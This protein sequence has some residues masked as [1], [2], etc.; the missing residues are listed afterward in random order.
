MESKNRFAAYV[1]GRVKAVREYPLTE[2]K[3]SCK[4]DVL[5]ACNDVYSS[6]IIFAQ[7]GAAAKRLG[8]PNI[9]QILSDSAEKI[10]NFFLVNQNNNIDKDYF[11]DFHNKICNEFLTSLNYARCSV[12]YVA[13]SYGS[14]QKFFNIVFKYLACY[15][16]YAQYENC[17]AW[18]HMPID[19]IVLKW[20][21][22]TYGISKIYYYIYLDKKGKTSLSASYK[23]RSWTKF[24]ESLYKELLNIIRNK[25]ASDSKFTNKTLLEVEFSIWG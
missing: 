11:D 18:C 13:L 21:K 4:A 2:R 8:T 5:A 17:F 15:L 3:I 10:Y 14:A 24:D 16:D 9:E 25:V 6:G 20:L 23:K 7:G 12:G 22:D 19:T 1:A